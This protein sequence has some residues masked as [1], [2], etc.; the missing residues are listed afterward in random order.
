MRALLAGVAPF[1][2]R[3]SMTAAAWRGRIWQFGGVGANTLT[4]SILDVS[5]E[6][7]SF[8][9]LAGAWHEESARGPGPRRCN[10]FAESGRALHLWGGS[11]VEQGPAGIRYTFLADH[12][13]LEP[14]ASEWRR[15]PDPPSG[16]CPRYWP[17]FAPLGERLF[18]AG[19]YTED[20]LGRRRLGDAWLFD[21]PSSWLPA[22]EG[23]EARY[24]AVSA[25]AGDA[26]YVYGGCSE[27]ADLDDLWRFDGD[28]WE[29]ISAPGAAGAPPARYCASVTLSGGS[30]IVFGGRSRF[31]PR[32]NYSD[33][34]AC[35]LATGGWELVHPGTDDHRYDGSGDRPAYHA[36]AATATLGEQMYVWG[37]EGRRGHVSDLWRLRL[38]ELAWELLQPA[39]PDDPV[40]W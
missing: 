14:D 30:L 3:R 39:R 29:C 35:D 16:P 6:L 21:G 23:P 37:G 27:Q 4:E 5:D 1:R 26:V 8:D 12:W 40:L 18:L 9:P 20:A 7:W 25:A 31:S 38:D 17:V 15:L 36:K 2:A 13:A 33:L 24:G 10:G 11:S 19:G 28:G 32:T 34:W 22:P